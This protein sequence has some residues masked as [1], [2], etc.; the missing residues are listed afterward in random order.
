MCPAELLRDLLQN[1][2]FSWLVY[3]RSSLV[4]HTLGYDRVSN[5]ELERVTE[6]ASQRMRTGTYLAT[7]AIPCS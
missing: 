4:H 6:G 5:F 3:R 2:V 1:T 7:L